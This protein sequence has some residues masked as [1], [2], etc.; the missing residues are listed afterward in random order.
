MLFIAC[1]NI[2]NLLL[3]R[4]TARRH[5]LAMRR[6]LGASGFRLARQLLAESLLLSAAGAAIGLLFARWGTSLL[7]SQLSTFRAVVTLDVPLDWRVLAFTAGVTITTALV[8]GIA[9]ALRAARVDP[10]DALKQQGRSL[11]GDGR[12]GLATTLVIAQ[13]AL[14]LVLVVAA[15]LFVRTF[16]SPGDRG[17][18]IRSGSR[19]HRHRRRAAQQNVPSRPYGVLR[20]PAQGCGSVPGVAHA[21]AAFLT[22]ASGMGW[23]NSFEGLDAADLPERERVVWFNAVSAGYFKAL[24]TVVLEGRDFTDV[25]RAGSPRV[26]IVNQAFARKYIKGRARSVRS[27]RAKVRRALRRRHLK[28][29]AWWRTQSTDRRGRESRPQSIWPCRNPLPRPASRWA[30]P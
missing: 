23:N 25:D 17:Y 4:A 28:S 19:A 10:N 3:A 27:S 11:T 26:A 1:A 9:P 6:A 16:A 29:S 13:V 18:R 20:T 14:S 30:P 8:F 15:G 12:R 24:G 5:E 7:V 21:G 22:P 2:A